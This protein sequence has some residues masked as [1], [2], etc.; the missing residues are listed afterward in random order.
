MADS[1][2]D[3]ASDPELVEEARR[4]SKDAY[5]ELVRR[6][7]GSLLSTAWRM[8][9][10][11]DAA[12]DVVQDAFLSGW[13][14]VRGFRGESGFYSWMR[15]IVINAAL[16]RMRRDAKAKLEPIDEQYEHGEDICSSNTSDGPEEMMERAETMG[17]I[18]RAVA[19][20]PDIYRVVFILRESEMM[21]YS[22]I[23]KTLGLNEGTV[24]SRLNMARSMLRESLR[25]EV[26]AA[27]SR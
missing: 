25:R 4:G 3:G 1:P 18:R 14:S 5:A 22:E 11:E 9:R 15:A 2:W 10:S 26:G 12:W 8:L 20:L 19:R 21:S 13:K 7:S 24:K 17:E 6:Y 23:A 27:E 16:G